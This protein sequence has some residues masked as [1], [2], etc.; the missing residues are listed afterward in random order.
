V[1][2]LSMQMSPFYWWSLINWWWYYYRKMFLRRAERIFWGG[3]QKRLKLKVTVNV[4][5]SEVVCGP[6]RLIE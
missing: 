1:P 3:H 4:T 6:P 5:F 2:T